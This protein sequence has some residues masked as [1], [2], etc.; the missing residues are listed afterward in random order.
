[1]VGN[2]SV[3]SPAFGLTLLAMYLRVQVDPAFHPEDSMTA[4]GLRIFQ[5]GQ[6]QCFDAMA[7]AVVEKR[8]TRA[9][10]FH[11]EPLQ[12]LADQYVLMS[13]ATL[14]LKGP[15][16]MGTGAKDEAAVPAAQLRLRNDACAA[17]SVI[18]H[19]IYPELDHQGTVN[20]SLMDST[21]F[22]KKAF[23][24]ETITGNCNS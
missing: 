22:V 6:T 20:G 4:E 15:V 5:M 13:Y 18:Q 23:A 14:K 19:H 17:G 3:V 1:M 7:K 2:S 21:P 11:V 24:G 10:A 16:F 12:L 9:S 8:I